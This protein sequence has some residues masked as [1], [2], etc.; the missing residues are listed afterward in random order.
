MHKEVISQEALLK[1]EMDRNN[2]FAIIDGVAHDDVAG[3][4]CRYEEKSLGGCLYTNEFRKE[5]E[6]MAPW[7]IKVDEKAI[8]FLQDKIWPN[9]KGWGWFFS[10]NIHQSHK[11]KDLV[12]HFQIWSRIKTVCGKDTLFYRFHE[13]RLLED[14]WNVCRAD[15]LKSFWGPM[16]KIYIKSE[17]DEFLSYSLDIQEKRS[18][19]LNLSFDDLFQVRQEHVDAL[20]KARKRFYIPNSAA[21]LRKNF[22]ARTKDL[23]ET[24]LIKFIEK[25]KAI[26]EK[27][28]FNDDASAVQYMSLALV[29]GSDFY[30]KE[31]WAKRVFR[32]EE[33]ARGMSRIERLFAAGKNAS[34]QQSINQKG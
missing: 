18:A 3:F 14:F 33:Y 16:D 17:E 10:L 20:I 22:P 23:S 25:E 8:D 6:N 27:H 5:H 34:K 31:P 1:I 2:L 13:P 4:C 19:N 30:N 21:I 11:I 32:E 24:E 15:E 28:G 9:D 29:F 12:H 7:L 26:A